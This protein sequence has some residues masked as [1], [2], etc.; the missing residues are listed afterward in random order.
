[1]LF[2]FVFNDFV[3]NL[4]MEVM[5][6][7]IFFMFLIIMEEVEKY[8]DKLLRWVIIMY[9]FFSKLDK[10]DKLSIVWWRKWWSKLKICLWYV[11]SKLKELVCSC[12]LIYNLFLFLGFKIVLYVLR[13]NKFCDLLNLIFV[14]VGVF[15]V[16]IGLMS[17]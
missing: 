14:C 9:L 5:G 2:R 4:F 12:W 16:V 17:V 15:F 10:F 8:F 7:I 3:Y 11:W 6:F 13:M 1:M